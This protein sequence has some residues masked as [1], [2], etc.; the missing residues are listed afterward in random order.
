[1]KNPHIDETLFKELKDVGNFAVNAAGAAAAA[2]SIK[3]IL[4]TPILDEE[5]ELTEASAKLLETAG[6]EIFA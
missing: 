1:M 2:C 3:A 4:D 6:K 5:G